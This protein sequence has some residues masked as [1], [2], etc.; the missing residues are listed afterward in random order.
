LLGGLVIVLSFALAAYIVADSRGIDRVLNAAGVFRIP[1]AIV[2]F[3]V[4]ATVPFSVT[5]A[6][7]VS[8]GV[9]FGPWLGAAINAA[10]IVI[11]APLSYFVAQRMSATFDLDRLMARMPAWAKRIQTSSPLFLIVVRLIPGLGGTVASQIAAEL[12]V[13]LWRQIYTMCIVAVPLCA[14]LA[15]GGHALSDYVAKLRGFIH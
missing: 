3:A 11:A 6:L 1:L 14:A 7:A 10:G 2:I 15:F 5:D 9:L 8:N 12:H 13:S 4:V